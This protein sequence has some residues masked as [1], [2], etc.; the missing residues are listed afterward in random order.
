MN[1]KEFS[2]NELFALQ[3][4]TLTMPKG[5]FYWLDRA[6]KE[7]QINATIGSALAPAC[8]FLPTDSTKIITCYLPTFHEILRTIP[9]ESIYPYAPIA[10]LPS[11]RKIWKQWILKKIS[12]SRPLPDHLLTDPIIVPGVTSALYLLL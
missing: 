6:K 3:Y 11:F 9:S 4:R 7:A 10:G 12:A 8:D 1:T 2:T 5:I